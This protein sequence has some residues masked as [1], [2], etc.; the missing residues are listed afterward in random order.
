[1]ANRSRHQVLRQ[2]GTTR[3]RT[4]DFP[5]TASDLLRHSWSKAGCTS[6]L[7]V[8]VALPGCIAKVTV[9]RTQDATVSA[10]CRRRELKTCSAVRHFAISLADVAASRSSLPLSSCSQEFR[11]ARV[12]YGIR[13]LLSNVKFGTRSLRQCPISATSM[14]ARCAPSPSSPAPSA[15][16]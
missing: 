10:T 7:I 14:I 1:M 6:R 16:R 15:R 5:V 11:A 8:K 2:P 4:H 13:L 3:V 12:R 9:L